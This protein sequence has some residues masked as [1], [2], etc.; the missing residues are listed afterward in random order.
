[1]KMMEKNLVSVSFVRMISLKVYSLAVDISFVLLVSTLGKLEIDLARS[2]NDKSIMVIIKLV[3]SSFVLI[4]L[5]SSKADRF[6]N[7]AVKYKR[8]LLVAPGER[9][10]GGEDE[11]EPDKEIEVH[12]FDAAEDLNQISEEE[13]TAI[14]N[15]ESLNPLSSKS[16]LIVRH[17]KLIRRNDPT[18]K[19]VI[20]SAWVES[21][22]VR[23]FS[24]SSFFKSTALTNY[25]LLSDSYGSFHQK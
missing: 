18:A 5:P 24:S 16:D 3:G 19:I 4:L 23:T 7:F 14:G 6:L 1:M 12:E 2:V 11:I 10:G 17:V 21:L 9:L 15:V 22:S 13:L 25:L 8:K 20:F